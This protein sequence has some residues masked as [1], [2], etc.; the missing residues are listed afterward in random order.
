MNVPFTWRGSGGNSQ[1]IAG[2]ENY[3]IY[4]TNLIFGNSLYT[5][6]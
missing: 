3:P 1:M 2:G 5:I 6:T 4:F